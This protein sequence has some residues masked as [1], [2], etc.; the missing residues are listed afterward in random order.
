MIPSDLRR[1]GLQELSLTL[2][3]DGPK[4]EVLNLGSLTRALY[5]NPGK[6]PVVTTVCI[7]GMHFLHTKHAAVL[8]SGPAV[9]FCP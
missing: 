4:M 7:T 9:H 1:E 3:D 6:F 8:K 5:Q 2:P